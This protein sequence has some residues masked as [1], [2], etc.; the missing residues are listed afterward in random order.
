MIYSNNNETSI[1]TEVRVVVRP[2]PPRL[3]SILPQ[4]NNRCLFLKKQLYC[5]RVFVRNVE[6]NTC[7]GENTFLYK[8]MTPFLDTLHSVLLLFF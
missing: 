6:K 3:F 4:M 2:S 8:E 1:G 7:E 5:A